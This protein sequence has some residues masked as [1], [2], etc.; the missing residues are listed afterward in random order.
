METL[1]SDSAK[2]EIS[3]KVLVI[4]YTYAITKNHQY[5]PHHQHKN[6]AELV[7]QTIKKQLVNNLM[8]RTGAPLPLI[9]S[10]LSNTPS[11]SGIA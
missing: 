6:Y 5:E 4:L 11:S 8:N 10:L 3:K 1:I 2:V 7:W 9:G